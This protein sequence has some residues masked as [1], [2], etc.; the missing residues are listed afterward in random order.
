MQPTDPKS[1]TEPGFEPSDVQVPV[2]L[3]FGVV[4]V[5]MMALS[6]L[7]SWVIFRL[8]FAEAQRADPKLSPLAVIETGDRRLGPRLVENEAADLDSVRGNEQAVLESYDWVDRSNGVVRIPID[9]AMELVAKE[10]AGS[11]AR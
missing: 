8:L 4:L 6:G 3:K 9:R 1:P 2:I 10:S 7:G 11:K 5:T